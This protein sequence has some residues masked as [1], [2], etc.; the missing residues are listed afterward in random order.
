M[1]KNAIVSLLLAPIL[2][3]SCSIINKF[4]TRDISWVD[5]KEKALSY[6]NDGYTEASVTGIFANK[7]DMTTDLNEKYIKE[8]GKWI[9]DESNETNHCRSQLVSVKEF[10]EALTLLYTESDI[11]KIYKF[12]NNLLE[13]LSYEMHTKSGKYTRETRI[14]YDKNGMP[15]TVYDKEDGSI[16]DITIYS[17]YD[18]KI[19]YK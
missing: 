5:F 12:K 6:E 14:F 9:G 7:K 8:E 4:T 13:G 19:T 2:L 1:K 18:I 10:A 16:E 3:G 15:K 11:A 17:T